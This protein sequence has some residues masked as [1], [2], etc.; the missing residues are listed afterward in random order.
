MHPQAEAGWSLGHSW[1]LG[2]FPLC[3]RPGSLAQA[4]TRRLEPRV[5]NGS[6]SPATGGT[7]LSVTAKEASHPKSNRQAAPRYWRRDADPGM[8]RSQD[9]EKD[10]VLHSNTTLYPKRFCLL[11]RSVRDFGI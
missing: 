11:F 3:G 7:V 5:P 8:D 9:T 1:A 2:D 4:A 10:R 6:S